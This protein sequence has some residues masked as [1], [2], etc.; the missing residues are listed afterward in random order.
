MASL[1]WL[2]GR[3][4]RLASHA[5]AV[6][7]EIQA[8][9]EP[10]WESRGK[11]AAAVR[12]VVEWC[13]FL[14]LPVERVLVFD[15]AEFTV[16]PVYFF[17]AAIIVLA[18]RRIPSGVRAMPTAVLALVAVLASLAATYDLRLSLG[19]TVWAV[20]VVVFSFAAVGQLQLS[21]ATIA[22]WVALYVKTGAL[23]AAIAIVQWGASFRETDL[24][25][26][27][28]GSAPR[29]HAL[30]LEPSFF[31]F[32]LVPALVLSV[33]T[34]FRLASAFLAS[35]VILTTSRSGLLGS[36]F[37][38]VIVLALAD[39][40][41]RRRVVF[42]AA[43]AVTALALQTIPALTEFH[44]QGAGPAGG[45][46][47]GSFVYK[48]VTAQDSAS[49]VPRLESWNLAGELFLDHPI[50]GIGVGAFGSA[51]HARGVA[52]SSPAQEVKTT[53]LWLEALSELGVL[54]FV[55]LLVWA[56]APLPALWR[57]RKVDSLALPLVAALAAAM[58]MFNFVQTWW[59]PY[60]WLPWILAYALWHAHAQPRPPSALP[61]T[62]A[63]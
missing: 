4:I 42:A 1:G 34:R 18:V 38:L 15:V 24:A 5:G 51:A 7:R 9:R 27:W 62:Q 46:N 37:A 28:L 40:P 11:T 58:L 54:G 14:F 20:F 47:Y 21:R 10:S 36:L 8:Y 13:F 31:A 55:A 49:A 43:A 33:A 12:S 29:V 26:A 52:L 44:P 50:T 6:D 63:T 48:G 60:R 25:Y 19:Y 30:A 32:Y 39:P 23:W 56:L 17:M 53:N 35:A 59:V 22:R 16:R 41:V 57:M 2:S 45:G 61:P 3:V